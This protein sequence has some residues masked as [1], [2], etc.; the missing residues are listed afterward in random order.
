M[1]EK[2]GLNPIRNRKWFIQSSCATSGDGIYEGLD[3][4]SNAIANK[5]WKKATGTNI[6][7]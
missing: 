5:E 1:S 6:T 7:S 4:L 3:W 2:L